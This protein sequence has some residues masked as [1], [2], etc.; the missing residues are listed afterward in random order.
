MIKQAS[1]QGCKVDKYL[2]INKC[3]TIQKNEGNNCMIISIAAR[4]VIDKIQHGFMIKIKNFQQSGAR[5]NIPHS[6]KGHI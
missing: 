1:L 6:N 5:G 4:E 2:Q 3:H